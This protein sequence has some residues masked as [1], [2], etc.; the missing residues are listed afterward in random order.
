MSVTQKKQGDPDHPFRTHTCGEI[1]VKHENQPVRLSGWVH[2]KRD[3][4]QLI[5]IDVRDHFG[6]SQV[7]FHH[8][9][10]ASNFDVAQNV[11]VESVI[12][13]QGLVMRRSDDTVNPALPT[14][15]SC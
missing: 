6:V 5:F 10:N 8:D 2:R 4:G 9:R 1:R 14:G 3:H 12:T 11:R 15:R 7:V 13:V